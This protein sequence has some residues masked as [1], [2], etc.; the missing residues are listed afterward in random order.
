M[1]IDACKYKIN[2]YPKLSCLGAKQG[3]KT[4]FMHKTIKFA[5]INTTTI[6]MVIPKMNIGN[7]PCQNINK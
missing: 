1:C 3:Q 4:Y 6:F 7:R 5:H 2:I